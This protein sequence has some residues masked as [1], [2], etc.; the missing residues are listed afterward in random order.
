[1]E[2]NQNLMRKPFE[3]QKLE[4]DRKKDTFTVRVNDAERKW[5]EEIKEDLNVASDSSALKF[6]A[7][8]GRNVLHRTFGRKILRYLFKKER[9]KLEDFRDF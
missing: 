1:M 3:P 5:L 7:F 4:E 9:Q 8:V 6:A 2:D